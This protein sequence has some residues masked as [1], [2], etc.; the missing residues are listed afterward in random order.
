MKLHLL[1]LSCEAQMINSQQIN[2]QSGPGPHAKDAQEIWRQMY[3]LVPAREQSRRCSATALMLLWNIH[4]QYPG[5]FKHAH[6]GM[7]WGKLNKTN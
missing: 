3:A 2:H 1:N 5:P 4:I 6:G 7:P